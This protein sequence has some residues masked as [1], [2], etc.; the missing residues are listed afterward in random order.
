[1]ENRKLKAE[2]IIF[3]SVFAFLAGVLWLGIDRPLYAAPLAG[4]V[5]GNQS[6]ATFTD[7][8]S[9]SRSVTSNAV[10]TIVQQVAALSLTSDGSKTAGAGSAVNFPHTLTNTGNGSDTFTFAMTNQAGDNFD[11]TGLAIFIDA[12]GNGVADN[13]T[14]ITSTGAIASGGLFRFVVSG[15]VPSAAT[16]AQTGVM[17]VTATSLFTGGV[18]AFNTDTTV[19]TGNAIVSITK[20]I[21]QSSGNPGSGPYTYTI[22]YTNTGNAAATA[23]GITDLIPAG[24][25]YVADSGRWN[26]TGSTVL[27][28]LSASDAQGTAPNTVTYDFGVTVGNRVT[29]VISQIT[30]GQSGTITFQVTV[31]NPLGPQTI[32]NIAQISYNDSVSVV[33]PFSSNAVGFTVNQSAGVNFSDTG[34]SATDADGTVNDIALVASATQG[35]TVAFTTIVS[36]AGNGV[37]SFDITISGSSFPA[38]TTFLLFQSDGVT[39]LLDTNGNGTPDTG[40][41]VSASASNI[42]IK[43]ILPGSASGGGP[44]SATGTATSFFNNTVSN[45]ITV[46]LTTIATNAVNVT[47]TPGGDAVATYAVNPGSTTVFPLSVINASGPADSYDLLADQDGAFGSTN[48]LPSGWT[49]VFLES[50]GADCSAANLGGVIT[51]TGTVNAGATKL[52]CAVISVPPGFTAGQVS[53]FFRAL[54]PVSG[55]ADIVQDA[56][57]VNIVRAL[58]FTPN[59]TD[60]AFQTGSATYAHLL[61]NN[62]NVIETAIALTTANNLAGWTSAIYEDTNSNGVLDAADAVITSVATLSAGASQTLFVKAFAPSGATVGTANVTTAAATAASTAT[63]SATDTTTVIAG[64]ISLFKEQALDAACDGIADT[65]FV[66]TDITFGAIPGACVRYR[67]TVTNTGTANALAVVVNDAT[68]A[69]TVYN[70]GGGT[71]PAATT[72]GAITTEPAVGSAGSIIATVGTLTPAQSAVITFGVQVNP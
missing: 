45:P 29:A 66:V 46:R 38:G 34:V 13:T 11:L 23:V 51:N 19:V 12:D 60:Q 68:P 42:V 50:L 72:V 35:A 48:D 65:A 20:A 9:V 6:T 52:V 14:P 63:A 16:S 56:V 58:T 41:S 57:D 10:R 18:N 49:A 39:P 59:N 21:S 43:A 1:M 28:D 7:A 71:A 36:N 3:L 69:N 33:G 22:S 26:V 37:D 64:D 17:R 15:I 30:S 24:L 54:S 47:N 5:I 62:G 67:V 55:A 40:P 27:T 44:Y 70:T 53:V 32:N 2:I 31:N 61:S 25:T 4:T 8:S